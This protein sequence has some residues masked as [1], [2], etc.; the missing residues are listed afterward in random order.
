MVLPFSGSGLLRHRYNQTTEWAGDA[1]CKT[2]EFTGAERMEQVPIHY[3]FGNSAE[4]VLNV[5]GH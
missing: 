3:A 2:E 4:A 1:F 5:D